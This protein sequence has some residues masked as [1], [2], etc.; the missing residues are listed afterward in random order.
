MY[1]C[2][3]GCQLISY[4]TKTEKAECDCK[5]QEDGIN[6]N[7]EDI[8]FSKEEIIDAFVGALQNSNFKVLKCYK[9]LLD[10]SKI[11]L[12]Y[13]FIIM[14]IILLSDFILILLY[15][16]MRRNKIAELIKYF[17]KIK[18]ETKG[19]NKNQN[20]KNNKIHIYQE[21]AKNKNKNNIKQ[22]KNKISFRRIKKS[23]KKLNIQNKKKI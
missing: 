19:I 13:G 16:I 9:L 15:I 6:T 17:I 23:P 10:F 14:S 3:T 20:Q 21:T 11:I 1:I 7:L 4:N 5:I 2:Q 22:N 18:F 12:N 8:S